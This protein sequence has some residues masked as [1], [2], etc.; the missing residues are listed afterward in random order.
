MRRDLGTG[1]LAH[2]GTEHRLFVAELGQRL[3]D[4]SLSP[5][6]SP[7]FG[8]AIPYCRERRLSNDLELRAHFKQTVAFARPQVAAFFRHPANPADSGSVI[9]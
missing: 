6:N 3:H 1:K 7:V 5:T 4:F 8:A 9:E 2:R